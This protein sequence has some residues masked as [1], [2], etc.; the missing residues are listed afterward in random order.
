M[1]GVA[2]N[3]LEAV[4]LLIDIHIHCVYGHPSKRRGTV[5][6]INQQQGTKQA[7]RIWLDTYRDPC[8]L[9]TS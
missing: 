8:P 7:L 9:T 6:C 1:Q 3:M 4:C 5:L 2:G